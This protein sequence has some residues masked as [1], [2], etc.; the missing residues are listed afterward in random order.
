[1]S[2]EK[3]DVDE[4]NII[5]NKVYNNNNTSE[6]SF[7]NCYLKK[8]MLSTLLMVEAGPHRLCCYCRHERLAPIS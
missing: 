1:M 4:Y 7:S 5:V 6:I 2:Y 3:L 8:Y